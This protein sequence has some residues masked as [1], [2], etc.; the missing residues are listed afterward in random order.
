MGSDSKVEFAE[1]IGLHKTRNVQL[2]LGWCSDF[3]WFFMCMRLKLEWNAEDWLKGSSGWNH[4][5]CVCKRLA[6]DVFKN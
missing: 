1:I 2:K 4:T 5:T 6:D 3:Y